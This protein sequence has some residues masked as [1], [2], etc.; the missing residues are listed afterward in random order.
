MPPLTRSGMNVE[1]VRRKQLDNKK[2]RQKQKERQKAKFPNYSSKYPRSAGYCNLTLSARVNI[3]IKT[4][5]L[6]EPRMRGP[7]RDGHAWLSA[8]RGDENPRLRT[9]A[10]FQWL[11]TEIEDHWLEEFEGFSDGEDVGI[12]QEAD[13]NARQGTEVERVGAV[14]TTTA[15]NT[16]ILLLY[17]HS[18]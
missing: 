14:D 8:A 16:V 15:S 12:T 13:A 5:V 17:C 18:I 3:G 6:A 4:G 10:A 11:D 1:E 7:I 9:N 2:R